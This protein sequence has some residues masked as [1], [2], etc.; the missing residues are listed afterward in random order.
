[1]TDFGLLNLKMEQIKFEI[2]NRDW[3]DG[4]GRI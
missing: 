2:I 4:G 1:M 3:N